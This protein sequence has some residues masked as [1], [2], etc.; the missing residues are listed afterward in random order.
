MTLFK[1]LILKEIFMSAKR[2]VQLLLVIAIML[3]SLGFTSRVSA[4]GCGPTVTVQWGDTLSGIAR[5]CGITVGAL[6]A[7]N[8]GIGYYIYAGQVIYISNAYYA[9]SYTP[10]Y[11]APGRTY[12]VQWGDTLRIIAA[13]YNTTE[14]AIL[15]VNPGIWNPNNIYAGQ[16]IYL[17][18]SASYYT[19]QS[20]DT[21]RIIAARYGT[22][23]EYLLAL[24]PTIWNP[25]RIY[26][27]QVIRVW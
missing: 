18:V 19:V 8:P 12:L 21:L 20:G 11:Y 17:P 9:P 1:I 14:A 15:A 26:A 25:N 22:T 2:T 13:R 10:T 4:W 16:Y 3:A 27:G 7:A 5:M 24:N 6:Y 23:V